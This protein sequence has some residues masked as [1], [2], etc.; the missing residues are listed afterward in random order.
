M[1]FVPPKDRVLEHSTSNSQTVFAVSGAVDASMNRFSAHMSVGDTTIGGVVE[2]GVAFKSGKL[3]YSAANEITIDSTGYESKGTFSSGG[4]KEVF[5][6]LPAKSALMVDGP[7]V[8]TAAQQKTVRSNAG[9]A[10]ANAIMNADF[11]I[12]HRAYV[13]GA[14]LAAGSYGHDRWKAGAS[15]GDYSF[16]QLASSTQIT[17][18]SGK[19]IIQVVEDK[20][21]EGGTYVLSWSGTAQARSGVN[22][23]TPS[24]SY[25][26]SP[27][28]ISGQTAGTVMSVEFGPGTL[29]KVK[30][31][32]GA[33]ATPFVMPD[34]SVE[35]MRCYRYCRPVY[36][37]GALVCSGSTSVYGSLYHPGMRAAPSV[38]ATGTF[39]V[40]NGSGNVTQSAANVAI[41]NNS[42][43][44]GMYAFGNFAGLI[45]TTPVI[46]SGSAPV[47][48]AT[49]EL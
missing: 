42:A 2:P 14:A 29:G 32:A 38:A 46:V 49:S 25:A 36:V 17:I 21:V 19:S 37:V 20:N 9:T 34:Y 5:M 43:D 12:N 33:V 11:R 27:L 18:A 26:S 10:D 45:S 28:V 8:L 41:V 13:S 23:A 44:G 48:L 31:E 24:G 3:T 47:L 7:Q 40:F 35:L 1:V 22:I 4:T 6:G 16:T 15:G 30:L 39:T